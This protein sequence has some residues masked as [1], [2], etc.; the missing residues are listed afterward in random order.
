MALSCYV[1]QTLICCWLLF[2]GFGLGLYGAFGQAELA[3]IAM[4]ISAIQ[5]IVCPLWLRRF[6]TGPLEALLRRASGR[7]RPRFPAL[8]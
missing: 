5:L 7:E 8:D 4:A 2:P 6:G 1:T 3:A